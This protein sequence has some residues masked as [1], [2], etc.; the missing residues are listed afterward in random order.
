LSGL[1]GSAKSL[2]RLPILLS[3]W[4]AMLSLL[5]LAAGVMA[6]IAGGPGWLLLGWA[7][8]FA[9]FATLLLFLGLVGDQVRLIAERTRG[10]PLVIEDARIN[11]PEAP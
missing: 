10:V 3:V 9:M 4:A 1:A 2:L 5:L 7:I 11:F 8:G 6:A